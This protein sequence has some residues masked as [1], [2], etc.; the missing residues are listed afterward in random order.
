MSDLDDDSW[1][2]KASCLSPISVA[3]FSKCDTDRGTVIARRLPLP[4]TASSVDTF[5][6]TMPTLPGRQCGS[7]S[8]PILIKPRLPKE[9]TRNSEVIMGRR[10]HSTRY[11]CIV[12][13]VATSV[14]A[15][16][17]SRSVVDWKGF[18]IRRNGT[19]V[20]GLRSPSLWISQLVA[21]AA[22]PDDID[23]PVPS[24][25]DPDWDPRAMNELRGLNISLNSLHGMVPFEVGSK[26]SQ[27]FLWWDRVPTELAALATALP[28][29]WL[30]KATLLGSYPIK[31]GLS[32]EMNNLP[33]SAGAMTDLMDLRNLAATARIPHGDLVVQTESKQEAPQATP[34]RSPVLDLDQERRR[35]LEYNKLQSRILMADLASL[36]LPPK[37]SQRYTVPLHFGSEWT[38]YSLL[39]IRGPVPLLLTQKWSRFTALS[40]WNTSMQHR[41][42]PP[43]SLLE[44]SPLVRETLVTLYQTSRAAGIKPLHTAAVPARDAMVQSC[45]TLKLFEVA[46]SRIAGTTP[47]LDFAN[48]IE[49]SKTLLEYSSVFSQDPMTGVLPT[50]LAD[51]ATSRLEL[52]HDRHLALGTSNQVISQV[53]LSNAWGN[54]SVSPLASREPV[55]ST[56][57]SELFDYWETGFDCRMHR[58]GHVWTIDM[59]S[60]ET[61]ECPNAFVGEGR[62]TLY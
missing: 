33:L 48:P 32:S 60:N 39:R 56:S 16:I 4:E 10:N 47:P 40:Y 26:A 58:P 61:K 1:D 8:P 20:V 29:D 51:S 25:D 28:M 22:L 19:P 7:S 6:I 36:A 59:K 27:P 38:R 35:Q 14:G 43:V 49:A 30:P 5:L 3:Q 24:D 31:I 34:A 37:A 54:D 17:V 45:S 46:E 12:L 18:Y 55:W 15:V 11:L 50:E 57:S 2:A 13:L 41:N 9:R 53:S 42:E 62:N 44:L 52:L 21:D 23:T